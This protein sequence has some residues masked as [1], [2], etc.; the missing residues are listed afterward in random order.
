VV[1]REVDRINYKN[2]IFNR[3]VKNTARLKRNRKTNLWK[4]GVVL[5]QN[6]EK[7]KA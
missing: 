4:T 7:W 6:F 1:I 5:A 3:M 2:K